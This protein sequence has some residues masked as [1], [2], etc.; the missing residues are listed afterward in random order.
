V[1][2]GLV[3]EVPKPVL[4]FGL[5]GTIPYIGTSVATIFL[6]REAGIAAAGESFGVGP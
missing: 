4:Q 3:E 5:A 6:A 1:T 2:K